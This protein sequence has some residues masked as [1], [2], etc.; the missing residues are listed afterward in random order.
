MKRTDLHML[1][2]GKEEDN[3]PATN[4]LATTLATAMPQPGEWDTRLV[5]ALHQL[6]SIGIATLE[7][8]MTVDRTHM[9]PAQ[10][11]KALVGSRKVKSKHLRAWNVVTHYLHTPQTQ[12]HNIFSA[13]TLN[14]IDKA[15]RAID[16]HVLQSLKAIWPANPTAQPANIL[17]LLLNIRERAEPMALQVRDEMADYIRKMM[18]RNRRLKGA[19]VRRQPSKPYKRKRASLT[20]YQ[21]YRRL[22][23]KLKQGSQTPTTEDNNALLKLYTEY[24]HTPDEIIT[25]TGLYR[26][27]PQVG[28]GKR[29]HKKGPTQHQAM[30]T[31]ASSLQPGWL[32]HVAQ[33]LGYSAS[34][35]QPALPEDEACFERFHRPCEHCQEPCRSAAGDVLNCSICGRLYHNHCLHSPQPTS[36]LTATVSYT[37]EECTTGYSSQDREN[38]PTTEATLH[39]DLCLY[40]VDWKPR[41]EA[42][43]R[44]TAVGT[45]TARAQLAQLLAQQT[46]AAR[47]P[48]PPRQSVP[49]AARTVSP[50]YPT[51]QLYD[52]TIGQHKRKQLVIHP[53]PI[54][55]HADIHATG[56]RALTIRQIPHHNASPQD[57]LTTASWPERACLHHVDGRCTH[58]LDVATAAQLRAR[59]LHVKTNHDKLFSKLNGGSF[60]EELYSL[61][62]RYSPGNIIHDIKISTRGQQ[63]L[64]QALHDLLHNLIGSSTERLASP[65][66]VAPSTAAYWS[67][68]DRDRLFGA[69]WNAYSV[70]WTGTSVVVPDH[71]DSTAIT[72]A[73]QWAQ[74]SART[75]A[76]PTLTLLVLP[77]YGKSGSEGGY[78]K[79]LKLHPHHCKHLLCL[80][81][82]SVKW[83][84]PANALHEKAVAGKYNINVIA[85]GNAEG[86][87]THLPYWT[88]GW[89]D[90]LKVRVQAALQPRFSQQTTNN[91]SYIANADA[92]WWKSP[93]QCSARKE[94]DNAPRRFR[95]LPTDSS[96]PKRTAGIAM[97][98]HA[99]NVTQAVQGAKG[100]LREVHGNPPGLR[101]DWRQF[102]YTDGSVISGKGNGEEREAS[103][104]GIG[105]AVHIPA[106]AQAA[107]EAMTVAISC[108]YRDDDELKTVL[109]TINRA[110]LAAIKIALEVA[111]QEL[112][113][114]LPA[115]AGRKEPASGREGQPSFNTITNN[116]TTH[117][118]SSV[119]NIATDS[120]ASMYQIWKWIT[121]PQD[122]REHRHASILHDICRI[123]EASPVPIHIWKVKSH[124]GIVGNEKADRA[125]VKV[126]TGEF[127]EYEQSEQT[128]NTCTPV[129]SMEDDEPLS[130]DSQNPNKDEEQLQWRH[131]FDKS[132]DREGQY[133]PH[134]R[135]VITGKDG[136]AKKHP[137]NPVPAMR[138]QRPSTRLASVAKTAVADKDHQK[139]RQ[140]NPG[141]T[142]AAGTTRQK[143][144][145]AST[146]IVHY[147]LS[148]MAE[149]LKVL[150][151]RHRRLG[152][153]NT[154]TVY[155]NSWQSQ[156]EH[157]DKAHS[158]LFMTS[159]KVT[160]RQ[161]K[162]ILQYRYGLLPTHKLLHRYHKVPTAK[163]PLCGGEDGG[164]HAISACPALSKAVT[165]RHN[166]A[167]TA[168]VNAIHQGR[169]GSMLL[170]SDVGWRKRHEGGDPPLPKAATTRN[171]PA[172]ALPDS[173]PTSVKQTLTKCSISDALMYAYDERYGKHHYIIVEIK[174]CRDTDPSLQQARAKDQ[175]QHLK[176]TIEQYEPQATVEQVTVLLGVSGVIYKSLRKVLQEKLG[177]GPPQVAALL[178]Q[179]HHIA[180]DSLDKIWRQRWAMINKTTLFG[181]YKDGRGR[182][183][184]TSHTLTFLNIRRQQRAA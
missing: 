176:Q 58:L 26:N 161:R 69:N 50:C 165:I 146:S 4:T 81:K 147:A 40:V 109:N 10:D 2:N 144:K 170:T 75:A 67:L 47:R 117:S 15:N 94:I 141:A 57:L 13:T 138:R 156:Q 131:Y 184:L 97:L 129:A 59:Y 178:T 1:R 56:K 160:P 27:T 62:M 124:I 32:M 120:L 153:S 98:M 39:S 45:T 73:M 162:C 127:Y 110:E 20:G 163:C 79:W 96:V 180:V 151:H 149:T 175:H 115:D 6:H 3:I 63:A 159:S 173:I 42:L 100:M 70:K 33:L 49:N 60:E 123:V 112:L 18:G 71:T 158:H 116:G 93:P 107:R 54:N 37:C 95:K 118:S 179:L 48:P 174:Y 155:Y 106:N 7:S 68:H 89:R 83:A 145:P 134:H 11:L 44:V 31:W 41:C 88:E 22:V 126:A 51:G 164:H 21:Q 16:L 108:E 30:V 133:W 66:N 65:L 14:N 119:L 85:V 182:G 168:I 140:S 154:N 113:G 111:P 82:S 61:V 136:D 64:P 36:S 128:Y 101:H 78:M 139:A 46:A 80:P 24:S 105:A 166:D 23:D 171:I 35:A 183:D 122:L 152:L 157:I 77:A 72:H 29:Q 74:Q 148:N 12:H 103:G 102:A 135:T 84:L 25:V 143:Q 125:A 28:K 181:S 167:G 142:T 43:E 92:A 86:F 169:K 91:S 53:L 38:G 114:A 5:Q 8:M 172:D 19:D 137:T 76:T 52:I 121:R 150:M 90:Q 34:C 99:N 132:N 87:R 17:H 55:P 177:V 130:S 104:P 9:R